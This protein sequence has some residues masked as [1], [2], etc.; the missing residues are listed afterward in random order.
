MMIASIARIPISLCCRRT[1]MCSV[2]MIIITLLWIPS[3]PTPSKMKPLNA[4]REFTLLLLEAP[5]PRRNRS[6]NLLEINTPS[7]RRSLLQALAPFAVLQRSP[8]LLD[9][10]GAAQASRDFS[11]PYS[12]DF[13][14]VVTKRGR[15]SG[16]EEISL[17]PGLRALFFFR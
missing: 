11:R 5:G 8:N 4:N 3:P 7:A 17:H 13:L 12:L 10:A 15:C 6:W 9:V 2:S 16:I 1:E 14:Y